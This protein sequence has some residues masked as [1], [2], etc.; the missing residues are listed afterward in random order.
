MMMSRMLDCRDLGGEDSRYWTW[1]REKDARMA[2]EQMQ[3]GLE[4]GENEASLLDSNDKHGVYT[5]HAE[6]E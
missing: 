5:P 2:A 6:R 1:R 3:M 4:L